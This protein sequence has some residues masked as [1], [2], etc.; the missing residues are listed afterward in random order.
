MKFVECVE[1]HEVKPHYSH[2]TCSRCYHRLFQRQPEQVLRRISKRPFKNIRH[3]QTPRICW[4]CLS[5]FSP[6]NRTRLQKFCSYACAGL[7]MHMRTYRGRIEVC[8]RCNQLRLIRNK[9]FCS[10]CYVYTRHLMNKMGMY[11]QCPT[12]I[13]RLA[14]KPLDSADKKV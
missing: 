6:T 10:P 3:K 5:Y 9:K 14:C 2:G 7:M 13:N 11:G 4:I 1:C 8:Q 12:R